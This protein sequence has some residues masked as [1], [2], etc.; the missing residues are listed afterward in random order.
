MEDKKDITGEEKRIV[1]L[2]RQFEIKGLFMALA[3]A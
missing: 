2:S 1:Y 3:A